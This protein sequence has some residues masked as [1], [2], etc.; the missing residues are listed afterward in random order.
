MIN[1]SV[2]FA[3]TFLT[4][5]SLITTNQYAQAETVF[6]PDAKGTC[7][8]DAEEFKTWLN[9]EPA[10]SGDPSPTAALSPFYDADSG[11]VYVFPPNSPAFVG[12]SDCH[13]YKWSSRM[14][15]W[16]TSSVND[17]AKTPPSDPKSPDKD[18]RYV[19]SS[20]FIYN[21]ENDTSD[22]GYKFKLAA[23]GLENQSAMQVRASKL[24]D[25]SLLPIDAEGNAQAGGAG[26]LL[27]Q[28]DNGVSKDSSLTYYSVQTNRVYGYF[29]NQAVNVA[30]TPS[31]IP[32]TGPEVCG[33]IKYAEDNGFASD[34]PIS[35][36][37]Y[38]YYCKGGSLEDAAGGELE[39][40][41][42]GNIIPKLETGIDFLSLALE[43]KSSWVLADSLENPGRHV[44]QM[45]QVP[46]YTKTTDEKWTKTGYETKEL[47][48]VGMHVV[49][50]AKG[51]PEM[52]WA[53]IEHVDNAPN[54]PYSY[55][56]TDGSIGSVDET[57]VPTDW[58]F[59]DGSNVTSVDETIK[60]DGSGNIVG[61]ND[62]KVEATN[63]NRLSPWGNQPSA[64]EV[65][66]NST[67]IN[68]TMLISL[69][70]SLRTLLLETSLGEDA[71][72]GKLFDDPRFN[73]FLS[74]AVWTNNGV[75]PT[76]N[77]D[78]DVT[79]SKMLANTTMETYQQGSGCFGCHSADSTAQPISVSHI[80]SHIN[81]K[82]P[83]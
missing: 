10:K 18:T 21:M 25:A 58:I 56:K 78:S 15:L 7:A 65:I 62:A 27:S 69:N 47:A 57:A 75:I 45:G 26:V 28:P 53:T 79:G 36:G 77:D 38:D 24:T 68:N 70:N 64:S 9:L 32:T 39:A 30:G 71:E 34:S 42:I 50:S 51:H 2:Y 41:S 6:P 76:F 17:V 67:E 37:L 20:E 5:A 83:K 23:Q 82:L 3:S 11:L 60:I 43:L 52:I 35:V 22:S 49:G 46:I 61:I 66:P 14:F 13:F 80:F 33:L 73:Y 59:S 4:A 1:R 48:L 8:V 55:I 72:E 19:F 29:R 44:R 16:L 54:H 74:G 12:G 81:P 63:V 40:T 31:L